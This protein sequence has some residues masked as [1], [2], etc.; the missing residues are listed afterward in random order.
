MGSWEDFRKLV[1]GSWYKFDPELEELA[2][3]QFESSLKKVK[4]RVIPWDHEQF[5]S[6]D[7]E[8]VKLE[9]HLS[10][11]Y[12]S[13][14]KGIFTYVSISSIKYLEERMNKLIMDTKLDWRI[15]S[16]AT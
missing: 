11:P 4:A 13:C 7:R 1:H 2:F 10:S 6:K 14:S 16:H 9:K 8:M 3:V 12:S 15:K 5:I